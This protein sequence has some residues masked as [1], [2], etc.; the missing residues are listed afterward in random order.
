MLTS[1]ITDSLAAFA[2]PVF[3]RLCAVVDKTGRNY[4]LHSSVAVAL[5][6][7]KLIKTNLQRQGYRLTE[8]SNDRLFMWDARTRTYQRLD[9]GTIRQLDDGTIGRQL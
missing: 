1:H 4:A 7:F 2:I 3:I 5:G 6:T 9:E 8:G